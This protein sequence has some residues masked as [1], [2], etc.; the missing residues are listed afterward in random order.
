MAPAVPA[1]STAILMLLP[2]LFDPYAAVRPAPGRAANP[3]PPD[4]VSLGRVS[5]NRISQSLDPA[6]VSR[7]SDRLLAAATSASGTFRVVRS[8]G[9]GREDFVLDKPNALSFRSASRVDVFDGREHVV[10]LPR[11]GAYERRDAATYGV[12]Y[13]IGFTAFLNPAAPSGSA[14]TVVPRFDL[15]RAAVANGRPVVR[16]RAVVGG[17]PIEVDVD[18]ATKL[19]T[20]WTWV[21]NG[22]TIVAAFENVVLNAPVPPG[23]FDLAA[24]TAGL[25]LRPTAEE[26]ALPA[27]G[28][29]APRFEGVATDGSRVALGDPG[30]GRRAAIVAFVTAGDQRS[31][32]A[33]A[34][35]GTLARRRDLRDVAFVAVVAAPSRGETRLLLKNTRFGGKTLDGDAAREARRGYGAAAPLA[36]VVVGPDGTVRARSVGYDEA[37]VLAALDAKAGG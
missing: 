12:P 17:E 37:T 23:T 11:E 36:L 9:V 6:A 20:G 34:S 10:V 3:A 28:A 16:R 29:P 32:D 22:E 33:L 31:A 8:G 7:E 1:E 21:H 30:A 25:R 19:P 5:L 24:L 2:L 27:V 14:P 13:L 35:L 15:G 26:A 18:P 4:R